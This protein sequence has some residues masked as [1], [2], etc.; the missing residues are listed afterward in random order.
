MVLGGQLHQ[1]KKTI[2]GEGGGGLGGL[3]DPFRLEYDPMQGTRVPA[4]QLPVDLTPERL[5]DR[6]RLTEVFDDLARRNEQISATQP[7][8]E[9]RSRA[10]AML[11][12]PSARRVFDLG[13]EPSSVLDHYGRTRFGQSCVLGRRLVEHG[14]PFV[15]V[16]WS[17]HVEAEEDAGDGGWDHHY[18]NFQIMQDRH[19]PWLDQALSALLIDLRE[20]GLL[21]STL[22][23]VMGEFGRSPKINDKAGRDH[24]EHCYSALLAG[25]GIRGGRI[26]GASDARGDRPHD[27]PLTPADVAATIHH[28]IGI[29]SE[30]AATLGLGVNGKIIHQLF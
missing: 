30:Q 28:A 19:A 3:Y 27:R 26:I 2:I 22:V 24:W 13:A 20:R 1:G 17:D 23:V 8:D 11:T 29:T 21:A 4:L 7:L 15:Q 6:L 16:N 10:L 9:Y 25:G 14:V 12:S 18:R 5:G